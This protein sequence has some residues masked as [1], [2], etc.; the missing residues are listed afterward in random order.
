M[1]SGVFDIVSLFFKE[2]L[3]LDYYYNNRPL[4]KTIAEAQRI[5]LM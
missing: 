5:G 4:I 1:Q 3:I 2:R